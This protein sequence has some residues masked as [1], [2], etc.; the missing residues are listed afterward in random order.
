MAVYG[1]TNDLQGGC[2]EENRKTA[3]PFV[4]DFTRF[5]PLEGGCVCIKTNRR[6]EER[7]GALS[8]SHTSL[9]R[10]VKCVKRPAL[11]RF[12]VPNGRKSPCKL[13]RGVAA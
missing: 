7:F 9:L 1:F 2:K 10:G 4:H 3:R 12:R 6:I 5:T 13:Y 8:Y 11:L